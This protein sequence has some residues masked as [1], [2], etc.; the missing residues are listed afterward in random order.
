MSALTAKQQRIAENIQRDAKSSPWVLRVTERKD[1]TGPVLEV[2]ERVDTEK[3]TQRLHEYGRIYNGTLRTCKQAIKYM[4]SQVLDSEGRPSGIQELIDDKI[5]FRGNIPLDETTGAKL[6][7]LF[8]LHPSI[9]SQERI[10]LMAWRIEK[11]TREETL[12]WLGK[13]TIP[14][15][16]KKS[17]SWAKSGLRIMLAGDTK[18]IEDIRAL[19]EQLRK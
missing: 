17:L 4:M 8:R 12:Y 9:Q 16:G 10:E 19:L 13:T 6:A 11:F 7:L 3:G 14:T 18:D 2:C 1:F 15:Y 5:A